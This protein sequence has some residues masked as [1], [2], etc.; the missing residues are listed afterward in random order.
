MKAIAHVWKNGRSTIG[1]VLGLNDTK[2]YKAYCAAVDGYNEKTDI[3][4]VLD[5]G[6][7]LT[8]SEA[9]GFFPGHNLTAKNYTV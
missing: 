7:K 1:F 2:E 4:H 8:L 3:Q 9:Q 6:T 5:W